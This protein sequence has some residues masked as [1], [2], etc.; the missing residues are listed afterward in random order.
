MPL[1]VKCVRDVWPKA[2][3]WSERTGI[4]VSVATPDSATTMHRT[5]GH[6]TTTSAARESLLQATA[7]SLVAHQMGGF[8]ADK[9]KAAFA[10]PP[11]TPAW[12]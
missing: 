2:I 10:I 11:I 3:D 8:D 6:S 12:R 7:L 4:A 1:V 5:V 9:T